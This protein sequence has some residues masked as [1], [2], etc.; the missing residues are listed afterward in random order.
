MTPPRDWPG[1]LAI[2]FTVVGLLN[3]LLSPASSGLNAIICLT[4]SG[5][6][7][8]MASYHYS[9]YRDEQMQRIVDG[10]RRTWW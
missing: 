8:V 1:V 5:A 7:F 10:K 2:V 9:S 3:V 6:S 4:M